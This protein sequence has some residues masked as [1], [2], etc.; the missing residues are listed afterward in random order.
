MEEE[1]TRSSKKARGAAGSGLTAFALRLAKHLAEEDGGVHKNLVLS[2]VSIHAALSLVAAGTRGTTLD[3]LLALL[4]A[5]SR[6]ELAEFA[7]AVAEGALADRSVSDSD[8]PLVAFA[9]ALWHEKAFALKPAYRAA[10]EESYRAKTRAVDFHNTPE[11]AVE[12]INSWV[13][14]VT[15]DL[16][17]SILPPGSVNSDT[18]LVITNAIYFKGRWSMPFDTKDTE[19]RQF[20]L[21]DGSTVR[22]PFM[23]GPEDLPIAVHQGFKVLKLAY[24]PDNNGP[25]FFS[26]CVF[27][28]G[29][30]DGLSGLLDRM[31]SS[32]NF[33][34]DHLPARCRETYE[35]WLPKFKLSFSSQI[36]GV[37]QAMG[38]KAAFGI[39]KKA[40]LEDMLEGSL[41]L[42]VKH[43]FHKAV[44]EAQRCINILFAGGGFNKL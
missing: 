40:D 8:E 29:A 4:G 18:S 19:T 28:P 24:L 44:I 35:V 34:W 21:L 11:K 3:E 12:T 32:P 16:I 7:R 25:R 10:A 1:A 9:C 41:P 43:V 14:K 26:M 42:V 30:R 15:K 36:N 6:D 27:L 2:P 23:L 22:V 38:M 13:S 31:A 39:G 5:A 33:L 20:H 17:T 37:L